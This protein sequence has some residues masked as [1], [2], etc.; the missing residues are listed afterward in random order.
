MGLLGGF[1]LA[2][3]AALLI[4]GLGF[5]VWVMFACVPFTIIFSIMTDYDV[6]TAPP[7]VGPAPGQSLNPF[8][9]GSPGWYQHNALMELEKQTEAQRKSAGNA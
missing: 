4:P 8:P 2:I 5:Q 7:T 6:K 3:A 9:H 1:F